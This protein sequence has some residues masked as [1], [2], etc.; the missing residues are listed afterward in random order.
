MSNNK[1]NSTNAQQ[2]EFEEKIIEI[3]RVAKKTKGG[4]RLGFTALA[5][6]GDKNG[7]VGVALCRGEHV[8]SAIKKAT[9]KAKKLMI[10]FPIVGEAKTIPHAIELQNGASHI[11]FKPAPAGT[12][13]RAGG[14]VRAVL[15]TAG[16]ENVVT[17]ILGTDNKKSN[18]D[19]TLM[20]LGKLKE[21]SEKVV[22]RFKKS[23]RQKVKK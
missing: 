15:E 22:K 12:G 14:P 23:K 10:S 7:K 5:V 4:D 17:K 13:I 3:K 1:M 16:I 11:L 18:V 6:V 21:P 2:S 8:I 9:R 19:T 20:A